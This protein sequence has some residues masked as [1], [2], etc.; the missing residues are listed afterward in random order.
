[1]GRIAVINPQIQIQKSLKKFPQSQ[2]ELLQAKAMWEQQ[3]QERSQLISANEKSLNPSMV[4]YP[5]ALVEPDVWY[6]RA[7]LNDKLN[8]STLE[9]GLPAGGFV[10]FIRTAK[11][12]MGDWDFPDAIHHESSVSIKHAG[13][14][15]DA[16]SGYTQDNPNS[17]WQVYLTPGG[18]RAFD[19]AEQYTP[20]QFAGGGLYKKNNPLNKFAQ[21]NIDENYGKISANRGNIKNRTFTPEEIAEIVNNNQLEKLAPWNINKAD[22]IDFGEDPLAPNQAWSARISGKP[23]RKEDFVAYPLGTVG[24]GIVNPYNRRIV[25]T[26]HDMPIMRSM[27]Q[28]GM[29]PGVLPTSGLELLNKH[30]DTIPTKYRVGIEQNLERMGV[31]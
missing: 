24:T 27:M 14:T 2:N 4:N 25:D 31:Y 5:Q 28:D 26:Y 13:D 11:V 16:L 9:N 15:Y 6:Q 22:P 20:R 21:L 29:Q 19:L 17:L 1:M 30:I 23:G 18:V 8:P 10:D 12:P 7:Y 3:M